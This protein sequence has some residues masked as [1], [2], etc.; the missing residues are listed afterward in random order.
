MNPWAG[1]G[2]VLAVLSALLLIARFAQ[3]VRTLEAEFS[4]KFV[5]IGMGLTC[6]FFPLIF[7]ESW[8]V[9]LLAILAVGNLLLVRYNPFLK[10][11]LGSVLGGV[12]RASW[13]EIYFPV[14]VAL[15]FWWSE[16]DP[17]LFIVPTLI[18]TLADGFGALAG[19]RYGQLRY[20]TDEGQKSAEGSLV[21]FVIAFMSTHVPVLLFSDAGRVESLLI[22]LTLGFLVML[23]EAASWEGLDNLFIPLLGFLLLDIYLDLSAVELA[24]RFI[25]AA[26]LTGFV[27]FWRSRTTLSHSAAIGG[28]F[29]GYVIWALGGWD[30]LAAPLIL[31]G[32]YAWIVPLRGQKDVAR[33]I[34]AVIRVMAGPMVFLALFLLLNEPAF[35]FPFYL[36]FACHLVNICVS[37]L[38]ESGKNS[39]RILGISTLLSWCVIMVPFVI[40]GREGELVARALLAIIPVLICGW[41]FLKTIRFSR[42]GVRRSILWLREGLLAPLV[43][44]LWILT[45]GLL[46]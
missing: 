17:V 36:S 4:R 25:V 35:L 2:V 13:G 1:I 34:H 3:Q 40:I 5:H 42:E 46:V 6:C 11:K 32:L 44:L 23:A 27:L 7:S 31:F 12:K 21:F 20:T 16:G 10:Q 33:D 39:W 38:H 45:I 29:F 14:S 8:P 43:S 9:M 41:V 18:L 15:V 22:G 28:S 30:W 19:V 26:L 24:L 37:R